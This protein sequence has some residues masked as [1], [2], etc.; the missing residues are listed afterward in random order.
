MSQ[1]PLFLI[2]HNDT[3]VIHTH[4][5]APSSPRLLCRAEPSHFALVYAS[6]APHHTHRISHVE[7][8]LSG[9]NVSSST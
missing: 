2:L 3:N 6:T 8:T 5:H 1:Q 7:A 9:W 4:A